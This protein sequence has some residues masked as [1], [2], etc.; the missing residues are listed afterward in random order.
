MSKMIM[1]QLGLTCTSEVGK[2]LIFN[3]KVQ[4]TIEQIKDLMLTMCSHPKIKTTCNFLVED[5]EVGNFS[6]ILRW[7]WKHF[8]WGYQ[9]LNGSP[10]ISARHYK[11]LSF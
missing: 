9:S 4:P 7:E 11:I 8:T 1:E 5:M 6:M 2:M 3:K 10:F